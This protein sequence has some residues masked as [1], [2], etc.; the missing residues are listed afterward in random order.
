LDLYAPEV[1][2]FDPNQEKR[3]DGLEAI[4]ARFPKV[5]MPIVDPRYEIIGPKVQQHGDVALLS[6]NLISYGKLAGQPESVLARWNSTEVYTR[7]NGKWKFIHSHG[8]F[9]KPQVKRPSL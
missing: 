2:Y 8:S 9:I 6:F 1:T 7:I 3:V 5:K 4:K